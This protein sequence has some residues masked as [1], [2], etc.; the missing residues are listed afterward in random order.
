MDFQAEMRKV[1]KR[2]KSGAG[3][4]NTYTPKL[5]NWIEIYSLAVWRQREFLNLIDVN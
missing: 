2:E 4:E 1:E 5:N 3:T